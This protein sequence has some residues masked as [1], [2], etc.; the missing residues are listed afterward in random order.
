MILVSDGGDNCAP[1]QPCSAARQIA[2]R[3][4]KLSISVVGLQ[5]ND[6]V[7]RQLECIAKAGG[8]TY[9]D[10]QDPEALKRELLAAF[11]RAFRAYEATG[12]PVQGTPDAESA[13]T[14]GEG[15]FLDEIRPGE[16]KTYA[17]DVGPGQKLF[18]S[19]VAVPERD[20]DGAGGFYGKLITPQGEELRE[21]SNV[22]DYQFLGQYGNIV[23]LGMRGPQTAAP[24]I[25]SEFQPGRWLVQLN[26]ESGDLSPA[27]IPVELGI[28]VLDPNE[29]AGEAKEPGETATPAPSGTP[30]PSA[31]PRQE[32]DGGGSGLALVIPGVAGLA[33]GAVGGFVAMR[34][35]RA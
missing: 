32:D 6:R 1:P 21:Q 7:R 26:L 17:V 11:A 9:V 33:I 4:L 29:E 8:G 19:A 5:V 23:D 35:R 3:G 24:G 10:A 2:R 13:P 16:T 14:I 25:E 34:R 28:Q 31:E 20:L 30:T 15:Q 12:T 22:L 27:A 18:A